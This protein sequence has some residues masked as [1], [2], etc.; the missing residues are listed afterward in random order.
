[1]PA[2]ASGAPADE[3]DAAGDRRQEMTRSLPVQFVVKG[4]G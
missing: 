1:M 2:A 3:H 4:I